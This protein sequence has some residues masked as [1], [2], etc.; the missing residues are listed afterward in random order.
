MCELNVSN[1]FNLGILPEALR[2][3]C[4]RCS[5]QQYEGGLRVITKLYYD[6]PVQYNRLK[7]KWDPTG[8]YHRR[9]EEYLRGLQFNVINTESTTR[10]SKVKMFICLTHS[11][12]H[13]NFH[14]FFYRKIN[15]TESQ[16]D[17]AANFSKNQTIVASASSNSQSVVPTNL[18]SNTVSNF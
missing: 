3:K 7:S 15:K 8:E 2:T 17:N 10:K 13:S 11:H 9:F 6:Y 12:L 5:S 4:A 18:P 14:F 1:R 16:N